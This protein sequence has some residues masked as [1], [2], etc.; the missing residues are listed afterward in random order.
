MLWLGKGIGGRDCVFSNASI[1][2]EEYTQIAMRACNNTFWMGCSKW[3]DNGESLQVVEGAANF[4]TSVVLPSEAGEHAG[5]CASSEASNHKQRV[6]CIGLSLIVNAA[7]HGKISTLT[8]KGWHDHLPGL[9]ENVR[10]PQPASRMKDEQQPPLRASA[11]ASRMMEEQQTSSCGER[12]RERERSRSRRPFFGVRERR[13]RDMYRGDVMD[14]G[15]VRGLGRG[16]RGRAIDP[17]RAELEEAERQA[18]EIDD[19]RELLRA[20]LESERQRSDRIE[21]LQVALSEERRRREGLLTEVDAAYREAEEAN[22]LVRKLREANSALEQKLGDVGARDGAWAA[23]NRKLV[24]AERELRTLRERNAQ[25]EDKNNELHTYS[26]AIEKSRRIALSRVSELEGQVAHMQKDGKR[27]HERILDL[28]ASLEGWKK[29]AS[30][31]SGGG[32]C[33]PL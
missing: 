20:Q 29:F 16:D 12:E 28:E 11:S 27:G 13:D 2:P 26:A 30:D 10:N 9:V 23:S 18:R 22:R 4:R 19:R 25:L 1:V 17:I 6:R 31:F 3:L 5:L 8:L 14:R 7:L 21:D 32:N 24:D 15:D 33:Q